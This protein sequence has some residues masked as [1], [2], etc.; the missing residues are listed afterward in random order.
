MS[1]SKVEFHKA[2]LALKLPW[3]VVRI[4]KTF[5]GP[6][7]MPLLSTEEDDYETYMIKIR[8]RHKGRAF[9]I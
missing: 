4:I 2:M 9:T 6:L 7:R 8:R 1:K 5:T 3:D